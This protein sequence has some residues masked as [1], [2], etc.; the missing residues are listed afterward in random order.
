MSK[1]L[2][3]YQRA[4]MGIWMVQVRKKGSAEEWC[5][6]GPD[7]FNTRSY[8]IASITPAPWEHLEYRVVRYMPELR[9]R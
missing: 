9:S 3:K 8:A 2:T 1:P 4:R 5:V 6:T 7:W